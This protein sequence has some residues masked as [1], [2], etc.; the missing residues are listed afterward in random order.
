MFSYKR[1]AEQV[2]YKLKKTL[3][4]GS[5]FCLLPIGKV[6]MYIKKCVCCLLCYNINALCRLWL[7]AQRVCAAAP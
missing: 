1:G 3:L 5:G 7:E 6:F 4:I 2:L